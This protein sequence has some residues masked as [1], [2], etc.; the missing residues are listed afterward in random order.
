MEIAFHGAAGEVTGSCFLVTA[1]GKRILV[2]CGLF[3]GADEARAEIQ[4][5]FGFTPK[6]VDYV[7]LTHG[8][9]DHCGRLALLTKQGFRGEIVA[10]G[11][12]R[13]LARLVLLDAAGLQREQARRAALHHQRRGDTPPAPLFDEMDV[14]DALD[15]FGRAA[16]YHTPI[17]LAKGITVTFRNAGH[18]LGSASLLLEVSEGG[19]RRRLLFS[20]DVGTG[21]SPLLSPPDPAPA[22]DVV[23]MESTYGDRPHQS[24]ESSVV[25]LRDAV[26]ATIGR[27]NVIIPTFALERAQEILYTLHGLVAR[28]ELPETLN[29]FLDSPMAISATEL[30]RRHPEAVSDHLRA[31]LAA[32]DDPFT[33][34]GLHISR[35]VADSMAINEI[36]SGAV[37]LAGA[38]MAT[39]G[40]VVHHLR[41]NLW[42][43]ECAVVFVGYAAAGTLARRI[44]DGQDGQRDV[45]IFGEEVRVAAR[46]HTIGGFSAHA[47]Q[48]GLL[49]WYQSAGAPQRTFIV[50]GEDGA[51]ETLAAR[52]TALGRAVALPALH[53]SYTL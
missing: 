12:T 40:R 37:I 19:A 1:A 51:R 21:Q 44:I 26:R 6:D 48:E 17:T 9:L 53:A 3:Q 42:R 13:D 45:R 31:L 43:P 22:A 4:S 20:G 30:F 38:G 39:G 8:H 28:G 2:D 27:G 46:I 33:L 36:H 15:R 49:R 32:G 16:T 25:E 34:P 11:A 10:T 5:D 14:F 35:D 7:L 52:L 50:H 18:I 29:V 41:H 24:L 47:D 23:V